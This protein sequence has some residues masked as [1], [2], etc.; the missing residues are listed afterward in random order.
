MSLASRSRRACSWAVL[1]VGALGSQG[2]ASAA[3][4]VE[5]QAPVGARQIVE[6]SAVGALDA[7]QRAALVALIEPELQRVGLSLVWSAA[8]ATRERLARANADRHTLMLAALD[9]RDRDYWKL[10]VVDVQRRRAAARALP[11]PGRNA[12]AAEGVASIVASAAAALREGLEVASASAEDVLGHSPALD[13]SGSS[14][15]PKGAD[16]SSEKIAAPKGVLQASPSL[17]G[18]AATLAENAPIQLGVSASVGVTWSQIGT[19]RLGAAWYEP[20]HFAS[21]FGAFRIERESVSISGARR[22]TLGSLG[23]EAALG[24]SGE[25]LRRAG[26]EPGVSV[27]A[28]GGSSVTRIGGFVLCRGSVGITDQIAIVVAAG[29]TWFPRRVEYVAAARE[30]FELTAPFRLVGT[31]QLEIELRVP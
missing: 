12:A 19:V 29:A 9:V 28:R 15:S 20:A 2:A 6:L 1:V 5:A 8:P 26:A 10:I 17:G 25:L 18:A 23:V 3:D 14:S 30:T 4:T 24:V 21:S 16:T 11:A 27:D 22:W 13:T 7:A 31:G